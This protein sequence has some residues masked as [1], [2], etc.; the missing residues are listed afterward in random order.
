MALISGA[1]NVTGTIAPTDTADVYATHDSTYGKGGYR[2]VYSLLDR[3]AITDDRRSDGMLVYVQ[4]ENKIYKLEDGVE[5]TNW[6]EFNVDSSAINYDSSNST[7]TS[8]TVQDA[9]DELSGNVHN[10]S[11]K[12]VD[13]TLIGGATGTGTVTNGDAVVIDTTVEYAEHDFSVG[14]TTK[15]ATGHSFVT[16]KYNIA[17][18]DSVVEV[19]IG[20][21]DLDKR[22]AFEISDS[23]VVS[24]PEMENNMITQAGNLTTKNYID[25]LIID[26]GSYDN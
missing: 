4:Q 18:A 22:N 17:K 21:S 5:N 13:Y 7:L 8:D 19:G 1:V 14:P 20:A 26:C 24:A 2:E 23:G 9:L 15:T 3:D 6:V 12:T 25:Y 10:F 11:T 16:G